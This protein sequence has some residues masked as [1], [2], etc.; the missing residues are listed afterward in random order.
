VPAASPS[1]HFSG[2]NALRFFAAFAIIIYHSTLETQAQLA[3]AVKTFLHNLPIG[4]DLFFIISG[5]LISYLLLTDKQAYICKKLLFLQ[6]ISLE[7]LT[8]YIFYKNEGKEF[9]HIKF[10]K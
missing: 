5:F 8:T 2:L 9:K 4:V 1:V 10:K 3:T 6:I 7:Y